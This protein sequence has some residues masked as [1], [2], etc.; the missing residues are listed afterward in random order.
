M[1]TMTDIRWLFAVGMVGAS[2]AYFPCVARRQSGAVGCL[3][4]WPSVGMCRRGVFHVGGQVDRWC[5]CHVGC[6]VSVLA[7]F[8][9]N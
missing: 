7:R 4:V 6:D 1:V 3:H 9:I 2:P 5:P 8:S